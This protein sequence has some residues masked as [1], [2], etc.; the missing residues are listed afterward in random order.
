MWRLAGRRR[1]P[2]AATGWALDS[3]GFTELRLHGGW[4]TSA[5]EYVS[6][7]RRYRDEIGNLEWAAPQNWMCEPFMSAKT[8]LTVREHQVRTVSND[9][10]LRHLAPDLPSSKA[11]S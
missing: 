6:A 5:V 7:V 11:R 4:R 1:L 10:H 3:G 2:R 9:L 8:G